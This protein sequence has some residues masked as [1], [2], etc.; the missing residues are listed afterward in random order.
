MCAAEEQGT[1]TMLLSDNIEVLNLHNPVW[2]AA[3]MAMTYKTLQQ[4]CPALAA[5]D[6]YA[7]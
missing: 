4:P 7:C 2:T 6:S 1:Y 5:L 3:C